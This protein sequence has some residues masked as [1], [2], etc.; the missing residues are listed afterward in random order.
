M[1]VTGRLLRIMMRPLKMRS[2]RFRLRSPERS[3]LGA[4]FI[5]A[6][7]I[8]CLFGCLIGCIPKYDQDYLLLKSEQEKILIKENTPARC[9]DGIDND[10][11]GFTDC[12]DSECSLL[13]VCGSVKVE[14]T[15]SQCMDGIDNDGDTAI[16]CEDTGCKSF[17]HCLPEA[18]CNDGKDNDRDGKIDCLDEDCALNLACLKKVENTEALCRDKIDNDGDGA[19]DCEDSD[20]QAF[21]FCLKPKENTEALCKDKLDNDADGKTDCDDPDCQAFAF[22]LVPNENTEA[23]CKDKLDNDADGKID[24]DDTECQSFAFCLSAKEN[25]L[26]LCTDHI[27][28]DGDNLVDCADPDCASIVS[29]S[30]NVVVTK[31]TNSAPDKDLGG[32]ITDVAPKWKWYLGDG[33]NDA[34]IASPSATIGASWGGIYMATGTTG[35]TRDTIDLGQFFLKKV[36]FSL[37]TTCAEDNLNLKTQWK[38]PNPADQAGSAY[39]ATLSIT[40]AKTNVA[41]KPADGQWHDYAV[42]YTNLVVNKYN[43]SR[44][45]LP[46]SVWCVDKAG[47]VSLDVKDLRF[48]GQSDVTCIQITGDPKYGASTFCD[49]Q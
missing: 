29:C 45:V 41:D 21:D 14:N 43:A 3:A 31:V 8:G 10:R 17:E 33:G 16:D 37:K 28:N 48:E 49:V 22:C 11:D 15:L 44:L 12:E 32:A 4:A 40:R 6:C 42:D 30:P 27:D 39:N 25:T 34:A 24:C 20:C 23:L 38:S 47:G 7:L 9:I 2:L 35:A 5:A 46:F 19:V 1:A 36:K 18:V 26:A 13:P